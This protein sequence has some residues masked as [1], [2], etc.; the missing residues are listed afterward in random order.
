MHLQRRQ[1]PATDRTS[2]VLTLH[3]HHDAHT[4][5]QEVMHFQHTSSKSQPSVPRFRPAFSSLQSVQGGNQLQASCCRG[6]LLLVQAYSLPIRQLIHMDGFSPQVSVSAAARHKLSCSAASLG[7]QVKP[8]KCEDFEEIW[9][10][11]ESRLKEVG[12]CVTCCAP[13]R[14]LSCI[15]LP[16]MIWSAPTS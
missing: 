8:D 5:A 10:K 4:D 15:H 1:V 3:C 7:L 12:C 11:R 2:A 14:L 6:L 13:S 9:R 16:Y